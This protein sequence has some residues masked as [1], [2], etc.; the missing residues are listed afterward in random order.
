[1]RPTPLCTWRRRFLAP[2]RYRRPV[3]E[4]NRKRLIVEPFQ[5]AFCPSP[6]TRGCS[7]DGSCPVSAYLPFPVL[8]PVALF[9]AVGVIFGDDAGSIKSPAGGF[10]RGFRQDGDV[11]VVSRDAG[12]FAVL[13]DRRLRG[14]QAD[15]A[16]ADRPF[17]EMKALS[18][19]ECLKTDGIRAAAKLQ[20]HP[21][22]RPYHAPSS[23]F[24]S[25]G[26]NARTHVRGRIDTNGGVGVPAS[27]PHVTQ[28]RH[29]RFSGELKPDLSHW[30]SRCR[31]GH[32][33]RWRLRPDGYS[34]CARFCP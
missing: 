10:R 2:C 24:T 28:L 31:S 27:R 7:H 22:A 34:G 29:A 17:R 23:G 6:R 16:D 8:S 26:S 13:G 25:G 15:V 33:A 11:V 30:P 4:Q 18:P 12:S 14:G 19:P 9:D 1:M 3:S 32:R 21:S 20:H 5:L